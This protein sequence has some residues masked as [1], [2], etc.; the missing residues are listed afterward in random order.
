MLRSSKHACTFSR[1]RT[2]LHAHSHKEESKQLPMRA[3]EHTF[4]CTHTHTRTR[5]RTR[6][7]PRPRTCTC[8][9][10]SCKLSLFN[11]HPSAIMRLPL[12]SHRR[13]AIS[14]NGINSKKAAENFYMFDANGLLSKS[15]YATLTEEQMSFARGDMQARQDSRE[16]TEQAEERGKV[17]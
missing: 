5:A 2:S 12:L 3:H 13:F 10:A 9:R 16:T 7:C 8:K 11:R 14:I 1:L 6:R 15:R 4:A 17:R